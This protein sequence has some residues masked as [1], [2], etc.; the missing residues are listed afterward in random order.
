[1]LI[2]LRERR[3]DPVPGIVA[4]AHED[5]ILG[6]R[7]LKPRDHLE[8]LPG[9]DARVVHAGERQDGGIGLAVLHVMIRGVAVHAV[10]LKGVLHRAELGRVELAVRRKLGSEHVAVTHVRHRGLHE[11]GVVDQRAVDQE[12]ARASPF[13]REPLLLRVSLLHEIARADRE[14]LHGLLLRPE[15]RGLMPRVPVL[16]AAA[17][18]RVRVDTAL[19]DPELDPRLEIGLFAQPVGAIPVEDGRRRS[20]LLRAFPHDDVDRELRAVRRFREH[21]LHLAVAEVGG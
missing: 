13:D 5:R 2:A 21:A 10:E 16:A 1:M 11:T 15:A 18:A 6:A 14:I 17:D 9:R 3:A 20:V 19:L 4:H 7:P 12:P 8:R